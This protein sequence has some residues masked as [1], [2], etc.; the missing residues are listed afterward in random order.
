MAELPPKRSQEDTIK[1][2]TTLAC[3]FGTK[4]RMTTLILA[5]EALKQGQRP[6]V[7]SSLIRP[8]ITPRFALSCSKELLIGLGDMAKNC[9]LHIQS[10]EQKSVKKS[11]STSYAEAY[12]CTGL[13]TNKTILA[14][15][16][17]EEIAL[18]EKR[19]TS[20]AHCPASNTMLRSG[21][22]D[23]KRLFNKGCKVGLGTDVS[24]HLEFIKKQEIKGTGEIKNA[25]GENTKYEP[26]Y[27]NGNFR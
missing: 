20:I 11:F 17:D 21:L 19:S 24:H 25:V 18:L 5:K 22:C 8:I 14:H 4:H 15:L 16:E 10:Y 1:N 6:F 2:G 3:Y 27:I 26:S 9:N 23:V 7:G 12:G 13:L